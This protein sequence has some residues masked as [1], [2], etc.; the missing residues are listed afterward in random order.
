MATLNKETRL[1][2]RQEI[3]RKKR[4]VEKSIQLIMG[5]VVKIKD[6]RDMEPSA[7]REGPLKTC[8]MGRWY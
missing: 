5:K 3:Y 7:R 8:D 6:L 1:P 2:K 4:K